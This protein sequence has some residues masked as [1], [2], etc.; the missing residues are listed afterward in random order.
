MRIDNDWLAAA[1]A[2]AIT[3]RRLA[4]GLTQ[5]Q[6]AERLEIG[7]E[8]VSRMERGTV[9]PSLLRLLELAEIYDCQVAEL[10]LEASPRSS[11]QAEMLAKMLD[12]LSD[13]DRALVMGVVEQLVDRLG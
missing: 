5:E 8:A 9:L 2:K 4:C 7:T 3:K 12:R 11:D 13:T 6:V 1:V 10:L